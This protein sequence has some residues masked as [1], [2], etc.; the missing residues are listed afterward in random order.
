VLRSLG[1]HRTT[2]RIYLIIDAVDESREDDSRQILQLLFGFCVNSF[3]TIK[4]FIA[5]RPV[6]ELEHLISGAHALIRMQDVNRPN[7]KRYVESFLGS[8]LNLRRSTCDEVT[9]YL[10]THCHGVFLWVRLIRDQLVG[11]VERGWSRNEI[12]DFLKSLPTELEEMYQLILQEIEYS[13]GDNRMGRRMF[14]L[15]LFA[16]RSFR[17]YELQYALAILDELDI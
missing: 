3:C 1:T 11:Y 15:V 17:V 5:S 13:D 4:V 6:G 2:K 14:E 7:I 8:E 12:F 9:K 16:C 10:L